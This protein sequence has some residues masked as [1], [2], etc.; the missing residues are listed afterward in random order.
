MQIP[1]VIADYA[2]CLGHSCMVYADQLRN[3]SAQG[4]RVA[5]KGVAE[6]TEYRPA[7]TTLS[8]LPVATM[9]SS[10]PPHFRMQQA[11]L[12][13]GKGCRLRC[14]TRTESKLEK[15]GTTA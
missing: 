1:L 7:R 5:S 4:I 11:A 6:G 9:M 2:E 14:Q 8:G 3:A 10:I 15:R 13:G 12:I